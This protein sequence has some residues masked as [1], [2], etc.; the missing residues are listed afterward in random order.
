MVMRL[1]IGDGFYVPP[2]SSDSS[3]S[4]SHGHSLGFRTLMGFPYDDFPGLKEFLDSQ[5]RRRKVKVDEPSRFERM[6][7][8]GSGDIFG[9]YDQAA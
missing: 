7:N 5:P 8:D 4:P 2:V 3:V 9:W 6:L 1:G